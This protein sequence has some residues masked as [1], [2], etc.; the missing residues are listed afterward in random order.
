[1]LTTND[2]SLWRKAWEYKDHGKSW[3]AVYNR[4]HK[5]GFRW[6]HDSF[7]TNFRMTEL[8]AAIGRIQLRKLPEW[9]LQRNATM[10]RLYS[11]L[12]NHPA[13]RIPRP[14]PPFGH[15]AYK[16]YLYV[17]PE[18]LKD[19]WTRDR[20]MTAITD[21]GLPCFSGS[22][23]EI[24]REKAFT[25]QGLGPRTPLLAAKE[26][27]ETSLQFLVHPGLG[28][29]YSRKL[30]SAVQEVLNEATRAGAGG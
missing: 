27:G 7:G 29:D 19:G 30:I 14:E 5:P 24:Y 20:I 17:R 10:N 22:C 15:A 16:A 4:E 13:L 18:L 26:L 25:S 9:T 11:A 8:Q 1:M 3:D 21:R 2:E 23:S 6:L 28:D 12:E